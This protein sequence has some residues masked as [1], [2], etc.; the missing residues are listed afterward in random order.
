MSQIALIDT[1]RCYPASFQRFWERY[2]Q[3]RKVGKAQALAAWQKATATTDPEVIIAAII[4]NPPRASSPDY[5]PH[6]ATWLNRRRW[7]DESAPAAIGGS[8]TQQINGAR[9]LLGLA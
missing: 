4:A 1:S 6:P 2:P 5:L 3:G 7:E 9:R 8:V